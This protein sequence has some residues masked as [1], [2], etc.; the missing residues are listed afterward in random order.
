MGKEK[1]KTDYKLLYHELLEKYED[2]FV[3][4]EQEKLNAYDEIDVIKE[5]IDSLKKENA[6]LRHTIGGYITQMARAKKELS[7]LKADYELAKK[8]VND[9]TKVSLEN[10]AMVKECIT[11]EEEMEESYKEQIRVLDRQI[12]KLTED[13]ADK[14]TQKDEAERTMIFYKE[15]YEYFKS[16]PWYKRIFWK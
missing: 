10:K 4:L 1:K 16:L 8:S 6:S 13:L 11:R 3:R 14:K 9:L 15:N 12:L 5:T 2:D 7:N